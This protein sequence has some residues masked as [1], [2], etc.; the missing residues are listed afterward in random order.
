MSGWP[1][2]FLAGHL[3]KKCFGEFFT[4]FCSLRPVQRP[5]GAG[6]AARWY[7]DSYSCREVLGHEVLGGEENGEEGE[8][9]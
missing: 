3:D 7:S 1:G 9:G 4:S 8:G 6:V 5:A 2:N